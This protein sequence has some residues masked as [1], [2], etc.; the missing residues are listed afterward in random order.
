LKHGL[1]LKTIAEMHNLF[2][3]EAAVYYF[4]A[5]EGWRQS[6]WTFESQV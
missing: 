1:T 3:P 5:L 4:S 2:G 6:F